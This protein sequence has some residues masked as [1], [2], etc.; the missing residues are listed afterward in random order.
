MDG[1]TISGFTLENYQVGNVWFT[2]KGGNFSGGQT[3][4]P[5]IFLKVAQYS[6]MCNGLIVVE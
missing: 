4:L 1:W 3:T 5:P 6:S 2:F